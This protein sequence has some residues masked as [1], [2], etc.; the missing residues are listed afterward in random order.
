[1]SY[2]PLLYKPYMQFKSFIRVG[3]LLTGST[4]IIS[5]E[6]PYDVTAVW[7][8]VQAKK[9]LITCATSQITLSEVCSDR[10]MEDAKT[11]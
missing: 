6:S 10:T 1:M 4:Y 5:H 7:D 8:Y 3:P 9:L 2:Y 11:E